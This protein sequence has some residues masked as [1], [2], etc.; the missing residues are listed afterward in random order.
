[1]DN[2]SGPTTK[3]E[4]EKALDELVLRAHAN[5]VEVDNGGFA[6]RHD[7]PEIPDWEVLITRTT[8]LGQSR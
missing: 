8:K 5:G 7:E 3:A 2:E 4:L 1:M 6:L